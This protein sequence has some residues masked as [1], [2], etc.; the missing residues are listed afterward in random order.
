M[1]GLF[2]IIINC[3]FDTNSGF[4]YLVILTLIDI[5]VKFILRKHN[6]VSIFNK[7]IYL[8]VG[9]FANYV[10]TFSIIINKLKKCLYIKN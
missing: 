10:K 6:S 7:Y 1:Q 4:F 9:R 5:I 3:L 2:E 8:N